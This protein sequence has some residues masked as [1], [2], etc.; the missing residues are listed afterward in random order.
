M[1]RVLAGLRVL[2]CLNVLK[3]KSQ[4]II[5][6]CVLF[7]VRSAQT[8]VFKIIWLFPDKNKTSLTRKT[9]NVR[10]RSGLQP[11]LTAVLFTLAV[12]V[13]LP[14]DIVQGLFHTTPEEFERRF[15]SENASNVYCPRYAGGNSHY[16]NAIVFKKLCFQNVFC[17]QSKACSSDKVKSHDFSL[18]L[19]NFFP[20]T[21]DNPG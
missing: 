9:Q 1:L 3:L 20:L 14:Q 19:E 13:R 7:I 17:P 15:H 2:L 10:Y 21:Y 18:T 12:T 8:S 11:P 6:I 4:K 16:R 5:H